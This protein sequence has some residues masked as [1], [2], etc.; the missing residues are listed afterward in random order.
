[1]DWR[2]FE[3]IFVQTGVYNLIGFMNRIILF[4]ISYNIRING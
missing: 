2:R 4:L 1:M 3:R